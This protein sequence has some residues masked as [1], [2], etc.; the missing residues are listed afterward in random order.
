VVLIPSQSL[1]DETFGA[2]GPSELALNSKL[3]RAPASPDDTR[4]T[5]NM[6]SSSN[7]LPV[8]ALAAAAIAAVLLGVPIQ[9]GAQGGILFSNL[10][11]FTNAAL[12]A[13]GMVQGT[14]GNFYGTTEGSGT[15]VPGAVFMVTRS[16]DFTNLVVFNGTNGSMP[17]G[18]LFLSKDGNFYGVTSEG[19]SGN[20]GTIFSMT[21]SGV[22]KTLARFEGTNGSNPAG[23]L[24][25]GPHGWYY[26]TAS[27]GG[28]N[29]VGAIFAWSSKMG[30]S[31]LYS[32]KG[33]DGSNPQGGLVTNRDGNLYGTTY[34]GGANG[35]GTVF[36]LTSS[37]TLTTLVSFAGTNGANPLGLVAAASGAMFGA[38]LAGGT[39]DL[40]TVFSVTT[41]GK[42]SVLASFGIANGS[43]PE[44][45]PI[46]AADG[47]LYG[48]TVQGGDYGKG[49]VI[50][51]STNSAS[52]GG[53]GKGGSAAGAVSNLFTFDGTNGAYP[54]AGIT[55]G[56]D[57]NLYGTTGSGGSNG[58]GNI[59]E[60]S[61]FA[62]TLAL[63]PASVN[64]TNGGTADFSVQAAGSEPLAFQWYYMDL[65]GTNVIQGATSNTLTVSHEVIS[66]AGSY[67]VIVSNSASAVTS[68][69][70]TL[71]IPA[72]TN[73]ITSP[74]TN[75]TTN[76]ARLTF[77]GTAEVKKGA[78]TDVVTN[79]LCQ[80]I[81]GTNLEIFLQGPANLQAQLLAASN[82]TSATTANHWTNWSTT[83]LL[84]P[85]TNL[86]RA[87]SVDRVGN[88]SPTNSVTVFY[89]TQ[90]ALHLLTNGHGSNKPGFANQPAANVTNGL[91]YTNLVVGANYTVTAVA[92][93]GWL[94]SNWTGTLT[95]NSNPL[96][97]LMV[98]NMTLTA[99]FA[100]NPFLYVAGTYN[101]LFYDVTNG[102]GAQSSGL[103]QSLAVSNNGAYA[104]ELYIGGT[105]YG[106]NGNFD[107]SG[108]ATNQISR[109]SGL[110]ALTLGMNL[111]WLASPPQV[112][113]TVQETNTGQKTSGGAWT[114]SLLAELA[115]SNLPSA[116]Y[117][118]LLPPG[119][120]SPPGD[121]Y[122]LIT[123]H[124]GAAFV[125]GALADGAAFGE[126]AAIS[127]TGALA[128][129]AAP[130]TNGGL[131]LGR[132]VLTNGAPEG[133]LTWIRPADAS[134]LF[135]KSFTNLVPV[136]SALWTNPPANTPIIP[137]TSGQLII[138]NTGAPLI[139]YVTVSNNNAVVK[140]AG[141][142]NSLAGSINPKTGLLS[143]TLG[144]G[145]AAA[146]GAGAFL[147]TSGSAAGFL[148]TTTS[149]GLMSLQTNLSAVAPI[150]CQQPAGQS[151]A[152][153][154][155]VQF[156]VQ[157]IGSPPLS[158]QWRMDGANLA[159]GG[160]IS[161]A[162]TNQLSVSNETLADAGHYSVV[163]SNLYGSATSAV[164]AL[165]V[166]IPVLAIKPPGANVTNAVLMVLGTASGK[167]GLTNVL[168][169]INGGA[170]GSAASTNQWTNWSALVTLQA[171]TNLFQ[172]YSV[173]PIGQHSQTNS[174]TVFYVTHSPLTLVTNGFG[175]ISRGFSGL[176]LVVDTNYAVAAVPNPGNLFSNWTGTITATNNPLTFLMV[177]N[178]VLTANFVTNS[179]LG[180]AGI[181]NGLFY[182]VTNGAAAESAGLLQSLTV[183]TNGTYS[184][185]L[186]IG[187]TNYSIRGSF[188]LAGDAACQV[189]RTNGL[190]LL[191]LAMHLN[192]D[193]TPPQITGTVQ[194]TNGGA[195]MA[196]LTNE[197]AGS[198]LPSAEYTMLMP[199]GPGAP[200]NSPAGYGYALITNHLGAVTVTG[201]LADG[202][203]FS[204]NIAESQNLRL[205]FYAA[206]YTSGLFTN[207]LLLGWLD[208]SGGAPAGSLT[209]IRPAAA[210]GL[211]PK[212]YTNAVTVQ[213]SAWTNFSSSAKG[214]L[215]LNEQLDV[216][217][218]F[219]AAP[220]VFDVAI[221]YTN[222][223]LEVL[224]GGPTN[225]LSGS[226]NAKTGFLNITFGNGNGTNT[227]AG[228][229]AI[230]QNNGRGGG[231]L[232]TSTNTGSF[233]LQP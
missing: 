18:P 226:I 166:P 197:P 51:V 40:G 201:A 52:G 79:V 72:P 44:A 127:Q 78:K 84:Q 74:K 16:G 216:S 194:G 212:G 7:L 83:N 183:G 214:I 118:L 38:T 217:G 113:G 159:N 160:R 149:A 207:G 56:A 168:C 170:W 111:N 132:L 137:T 175:T 108:N 24:V 103:L 181:Y 154:S 178:M 90:S 75:L 39:N 88:P 122:A 102:V 184:G 43:N 173:D 9:A 131:L 232:I 3:D 68:S 153:N 73:T 47:F 35:A 176:N 182:D 189:P 104:G 141:A 114:A 167:Y 205:P 152:L 67:F 63:Q 80:I 119:K 136:Q 32:F 77:Q 126:N 20:N 211:F 161:G 138:S 25:L 53:R 54:E 106:V 223:N 130:Y 17:A 105:N 135:T 228:T 70:V 64:F 227:T 58:Y 225:S 99:N 46:L 107:F 48:T 219:L 101:G 91:L 169:Q 120:N 37:N 220:L 171:G 13:A 115:A 222:S 45:P 233:S 123:N 33:A 129:Y 2:A 215:W 8:R 6:N 203:A 61:G 195:W 41:A 151:L 92:S 139:F 121:G 62:T 87:Y 199:P 158:Y 206:P 71:T 5:K 164:A 146:T 128:I 186:Y 218:A 27:S 29:K 231:Y 96:T 28:S 117:T 112:T 213:S 190:G 30:V 76:T 50:R 100:T 125:T 95:T 174:V 143:V 26:G 4:G 1:S 185:K 202:A 156:S 163:V 196:E 98:S 172:A 59:F 116:Q 134:G 14:N 31:N 192:W 11:S 124:A 208:L 142:T 187:G 150:I 110:G 66:D 157:A 86:F 140:L 145:K 177:S 148:V 15:N 162:A 198:N 193:I 93:P 221:N 224:A 21:Q 49:L 94:F 42:L 147:Q 82:W 179:F 85:G 36:R 165:T 230:L 229:G 180:A 69:V 210:G 12:P 23:G 144:S 200:T 97:F 10:Y 191:S 19:G 65:A 22:F 109:A 209:W 188:D 89:Y 204:Q 34:Q 55:Q 133:N 60:L 155:N 57:L 81:A